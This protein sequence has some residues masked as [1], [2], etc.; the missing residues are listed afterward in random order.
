MARS[1]LLLLALA[2]S[3]CVLS[4]Y[5]QYDT[6]KSRRRLSDAQQC[7]IQR[8]SASTPS[9][10]IR[11]EGGVTELWDYNEDQFQCAGV[12]AMKNT[13]QPNGLSL[14]NYSPSPRLVY[15]ERGRGVLGITFPGCQ[16]SYHSV[17]GQTREG[18]RGEQQQQTGEEDQHQKV[19]RIVQGQIVALPAGAAHWL[20]NDGNEDLVAVSVTDV[21]NGAN[22]LDQRPRSFYL[23][24]GRPRQAGGAGSEEEF[25]AENVIRPFDA[26]LMADALG[27]SEQTV[28]RMQENDERGFIVLAK[29]EEMRMI[30]PEEEE[31]EEERYRRG[32][33]R[34]DNN[35]GVSNGLEEAYCNMKVNQNIDNPRDADVYSRQAGRINSVNMHKLPI[36]SYLDMSAEKGNLYE[37]SVYLPHWEMNSHSIVY[38]TRGSARIQVVGSN[39]KTVL[40]EE[41]RRGQLVVVPQY[42]ASIVRASQ[43]GFE[44]ISFKTS[45]LPMKSPL[46]GA[47]SALKGMPI[48]VLVNS[49]RIS[50]RQAQDVKYN[51]ERHPYFVPGSGQ[52]QQYVATASA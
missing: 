5:A 32:S 38:V 43:N 22:Q 12:A 8:L 17:R 44:W 13:I 46:A 28:R 50:N 7:R 1:V 33:S 26:R 14:P 19:H 34:G 20:Y 29:Q 6:G 41:V 31:E 2:L 25:D 10:R 15:I 27:V 36:L 49:Y 39:G 21:N 30:R 18:S 23:A 3:L 40:D 51:R 9:R 37:N 47:R 24:G 16:E 45:A 35:E 52:Q 48:P 42:F 4:A 11:S